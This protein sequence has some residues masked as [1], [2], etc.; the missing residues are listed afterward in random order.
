[1]IIFKIIKRHFHKNFIFMIIFILCQI[2]SVISADF[3]VSYVSARNEYNNRFDE[4]IRTVQINNLRESDNAFDSIKHVNEQYKDIIAKCYAWTTYNGY[5]VKINLTGYAE[6]DTYISVGD[7]LSNQ[8]EFECVI[9]PMLGTEFYDVIVGDDLTI[10]GN[11]YVVV[12]MFPYN[13]IE[14]PYGSSVA[15]LQ[16]EKYEVVFDYNTDNQE[17][18]NCIA[19][20]RSYFADTSL[21]QIRSFGHISLD[22]REIVLVLLILVV[23]NLNFCYLYLYVI[24]EDSEV[25]SV[26]KVLGASST[27]VRR[28]FMIEV[29]CLSL[30]GTIFATLLF[31]I[32]IT[33]ILSSVNSGLNFALSIDKIII[34]A[35]V[36]MIS[37]CTIFVPLLSKR[38]RDVKAV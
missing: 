26:F 16:I 2:I 35:L 29:I 3:I 21:S 17:I 30:L 1:M 5:T 25:L 11:K 23:I 32:F 36:Q 19:L 27:R 28:W 24:D 10:N 37:I 31:Q 6:A 33:K 20:L 8:S 13:Y 15:K 18:N 34:V 4:T 7:Y 9:N 12:G 14:I 22:I 38:Y